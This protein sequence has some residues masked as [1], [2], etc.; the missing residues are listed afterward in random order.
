MSTSLTVTR[1]ENHTNRL[2]DAVYVEIEEMKIA[3]I[4]IYKPPSSDTHS[5]EDILQHIKDWTSHTRKE[6]VLIGDLNFPDLN[7]LSESNKDG[8]REGIIGKNKSQW[9]REL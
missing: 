9:G 4:N 8:L 6:L 1:N 7:S 5:F 2:C 3:D